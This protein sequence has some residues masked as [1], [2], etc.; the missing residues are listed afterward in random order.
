MTSQHL[1]L[2]HLEE[3]WHVARFSKVL[4]CFRTRKLKPWQNLKPY[5]YAELFYSHILYVFNIQGVTGLYTSVLRYWLSKH[6]FPGP[7]S[8]RGFRETGPEK[9][10]C[11]HDTVYETHVAMFDRLRLAC[12]NKVSGPYHE[13]IIENWLLKLTWIRFQESWN[14]NCTIHHSNPV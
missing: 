8:F 14:L 3:I 1:K 9:Q 13:W 11:M 7:N 2:L 6:G 4:I 5:D 10:Y 12:V